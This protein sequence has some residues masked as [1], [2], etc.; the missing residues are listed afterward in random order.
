MPDSLDSNVYMAE[1]RKSYR[2]PAKQFRTPSNASDSLSFLLP[3]ITTL[4]QA[5]EALRF[6][7]V[8]KPADPH[9]I[10]VGEAVQ[11]Y[12]RLPL[13]YLA[14]R[15]VGELFLQILA[16][17]RL[18]STLRDPCAI[19]YA[20]FYNDQD[21]AGTLEPPAAPDFLH[22]LEG[23]AF[24]LVGVAGCGRTAFLQRVRAALGRPRKMVREAGSGPREM[25]FMPVLIVSWPKSGTKKELFQNFRSAFIS[26]IGSSGSAN[27]MFTFFSGKNA[28]NAVIAT[29]VLLNLGLLVVDGG[30]K[31]ALEHGETSEVLDFISTFQSRTGIP[32]IVSGTYIFDLAVMKRGSRSTKFGTCG[33]AYFDAV[34]APCSGKTVKGD[35]KHL[36]TQLSDWQWKL[37]HREFAVPPPEFFAKATWDLTAGVHQQFC[38]ACNDLHQKILHDPGLLE[39]DAMTE[40]RL[41]ELF[42]VRL[43]SFQEPLRVITTF[44]ESRQVDK[45]DLIAYADYLPFEAFQTSFARSTFR[46]SR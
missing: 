16:A 29:C 45:D 23:T 10:D 6:R 22:S 32:V 14:T 2:L 17:M 34:P 35:P 46:M 27:K 26:E 5:V 21:I 13:A 40:E 7:G 12:A 1:K 3:K 15:E 18:S 28:Q 20:R 30:C 38:E 41:R 4:D 11:Q 33:A 39:P 44:R 42:S 19:R 31:A 24:K 8:E 25:Y 9:N 37:G 43:R 36:W